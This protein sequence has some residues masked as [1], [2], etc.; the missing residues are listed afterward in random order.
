MVRS[1][2]GSSGVIFTLDTD[3]GFKE[4][5][6]ITSSYGLGENI[7]QGAVNP[8][9]FHV[10]K[11]TL[12]QGFRPIIK[13]YLG[14]KQV[15]LVYT[16]DAPS[17]LENVPVTDYDQHHFSLTDDE[18]LQLA[19]YAVTIEHHY[20]ALQGSW[21]P[22][23]I[24]WAK[25][26]IDQRLYI[27]QARP[28]TVYG[29]KKSQKLLIRY[30]L[31]NECENIVT[32]GLSIGQKIAHGRAR[33]LKNIQEYAQ[34]NEGDIL[35]ASMTDPDWVPLMKKAAAII[36]D[37]GGRT[38]H[39][40]IVS[41][42]L[43]IPAVIGTGNGTELL[44]ND[45]YYTVD[46]SRGATGYVYEGALEYEVLQTPLNHLPTPRVPL[47]INVADPDR[48]YRHSFLPTSGVGL[49][50]LEFIITNAIKVHPMAVCSPGTLR[51]PQVKKL[52]EERAAAYDDPISYY[53]DTLAQ[54]IGMIAAA[55]YPRPVTVR[56]SDFKSNEYRNLLGGEYFEPIEE[57][58]MIGF[59][60][61]VRYC[62]PAYAPAFALEC[63]ALKKVRNVMGLTNVQ[64]MI[65]FVRNLNEASCTI[66]ALKQQGLVRGENG[67]T[68]LMMCEVPSNVILLEEFT[69][70]FDGFSIG[71][72]DLTQLTLAV[73]RDSELLSP[74]F[75][76]K[77]PAVMKMLKL[78]LE[79]AK[80]VGTYMSICGEAPSDYP[81]IAHFLI[82]NGI[83]ALSLNPDSV[84][85]FLLKEC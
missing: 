14:S 39:A 56:L 20:S 71:S 13:K 1:D 53:R 57:N 3:T 19:R 41:R 55:F 54:G 30:R 26:G 68:I 29:Q 67:L 76:E 83:D 11:P 51:D 34:F 23:D 72:N 6:V 84:I 12:E 7:V 16:Q 38:C 65:P 47:L 59:R 9:E 21:C 61:A 42:E 60:G 85:P 32:T 8:D 52:I 78:A 82:D 15:K 33:I 45:D 27:V 77:D 5:V 18:I 63:D 49:A 74:L 4:S 69:V 79:G 17:S 28:E 75:N 35:I 22:M 44:R 43:G 50:R 24:E 40:A 31:K 58:P 36:T 37:R 80:K 46:C 73:D 66:A 2:K 64:I 70:F 48:A 10:H 25:D 81:E 62:D